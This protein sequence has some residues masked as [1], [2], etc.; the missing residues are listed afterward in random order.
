MARTKTSGFFFKAS[1]EEMA[2]IE[3]RMAQTNITNKSAF[4]RKM[5]IDGHVYNLDLSELNEIG[6]LIRVTA[7]NLNQLTKRVNGGGHAYR[8]DVAHI[9]KQFTEIREDFGKLLD[10]LA[11]IADPKPGKVF[12]KPITIQEIR[13][14]FAENPQTQTE[15]TAAIATPTQAA[16]TVT[17]DGE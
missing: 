17:G 9:E 6:R 15:E 2:W 13:E 11:A 7:N 5:A 14:Y 10:A 3:K 1:P 12:Y 8:E 16:I 4:L